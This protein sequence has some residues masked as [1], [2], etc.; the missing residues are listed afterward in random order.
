MTTVSV[1]SL[2]YYSTARVTLKTLANKR[3]ANVFLRFQRV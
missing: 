3:Q 2:I 1:L